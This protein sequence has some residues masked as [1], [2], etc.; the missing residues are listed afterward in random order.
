MIFFCIS[1]KL[2]T[3]LNKNNITKNKMGIPK[4]RVTQDFG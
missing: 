4:H 3:K 1:Y 2:Q